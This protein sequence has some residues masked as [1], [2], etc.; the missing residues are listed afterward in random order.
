VSSAAPSPRNNSP[1]SP[2][3]HAISAGSSTCAISIIRIFTLHAAIESKDP[4]WDNTAAA[5]WSVVELNFALICCCLPTLRPLVAKV[6]PGCWGSSSSPARRGAANRDAAAFATSRT[7]T[8][9]GPLLANAS[10]VDDAGPPAVRDD[11]VA[12]S[13]SAEGLKTTA[14]CYAT[15]VAGGPSSVANSDS[16]GNGMQ[17]V[18]NNKMEIMVTRETAIVTNSK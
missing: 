7:R 9:K 5:C 2:P 13:D 6:R 10:S 15:P 3:D 4:T 18:F 12:R 1:A 8:T 16:E 11:E 14:A 17:A